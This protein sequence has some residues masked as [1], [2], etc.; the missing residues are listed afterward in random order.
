MNKTLA[1]LHLPNG[2]LVTDVKVNGAPIYYTPFTERGRPAVLLPVELP[3]R[4]PQTIEVDFF[5]PGS[6]E[7]GQVAE[8]PLLAPQ[9]T[10]VQDVPCQSAQDEAE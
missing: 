3:T 4:T 9:T 1:Q 5:E 7:P 6:S 8:Q 10:T 2:A